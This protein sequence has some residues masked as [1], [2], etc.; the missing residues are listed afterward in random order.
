M[1]DDHPLGEGAKQYE[2]TY[3]MEPEGYGEGAKFQRHQVLD[4]NVHMLVFITY[5]WSAP[6]FCATEL[7]FCF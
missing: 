4:L 6:T 1:L 5:L 3:I 2:N 7:L